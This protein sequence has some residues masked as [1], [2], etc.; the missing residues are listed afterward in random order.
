[1]PFQKGQSGNPGGR[2]K[3]DYRIKDLAKK[4]TDLALK[5]LATICEHSDNDSA[6][7][8]ASEAL[9]NRGWGKPAQPIEHGGEIRHVA[10]MTEAELERIA[11][12]G[13]AG[14]AESTQS[15]SEPSPIH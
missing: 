7:V 6:R 15:P 1:M 2:P 3:A 11:A 4:H 9:L 14:T 10:D 8:A 13:S 12:G 5:T